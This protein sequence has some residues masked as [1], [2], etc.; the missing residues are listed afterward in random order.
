MEKVK[1]V[2]L[3]QQKGVTKLQKL[4][5]NP[6][7]LSKWSI[8]RKLIKKQLSYE[9]QKVTDLT[10]KC[11]ELE[12]EV[13]TLKLKL[14]LSDIEIPDN[15]ETEKYITFNVDLVNQ[16]ETT[17]T[18]QITNSDLDYYNTIDIDIE[19]MV[20]YFDED[21]DSSD[22]IDYIENNYI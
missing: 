13:R 6:Q 16:N 19:D 11:I 22:I 18:Y 8:G 9:S 5:P 7:Q 3:I 14:K 12:R 21:F 15:F 1:T 17:I 4:K 20:K 2:D 10:K